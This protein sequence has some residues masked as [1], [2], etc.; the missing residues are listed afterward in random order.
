MVET[1][2]EC[3]YYIMINAD[4]PSHKFFDDVNVGD[5]LKLTGDITSGNCEFTLIE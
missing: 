2:E 1:F 5:Y 4:Y 3:E